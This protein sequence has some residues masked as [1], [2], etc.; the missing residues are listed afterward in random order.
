MIINNNYKYS[1]AVKNNDVLRESYNELTRNTFGFDFVNW[2]E[3]GHWGEMYIPHAITD[4]D[5]VISSIS[6]NLMQFDVGGVKKNYI[7]L[8][9]V[10]TDTQYR[11][12]GLNRKIMEEVLK[13]YEGKVDG[14][15]LFAN[16]SVLNYYTK[17]GFKPSKEYEYYMQ[18]EDKEN[19]KSYVI[20]KVDM[21]H[22]EQCER[23]YDVI[24]NYSDDTN[25][26]NENDAMYMSDNIG[27]YQFWLAA[28]YGKHV[29]YLPEI[30]NYVVAELKGDTLYIYQIFGKQQVDINRL[31]KSFGEKVNEVVLQY[32]PVNK[33]NF[34]VREHKEEDCTLFILGE[35]LQC[36]ER[37]KMMFPILSHA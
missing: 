37:N 3:L 6:V 36:V 13:E 26:L 5:K 9:T 8:G 17:F 10:M 7:Q 1:I 29:Y 27:L 33:E 19:I 21:T 2:Y 25:N 28:E 35:D 16:D 23:L 24:R 14:I 4:G 15:Y 12:R 11:E 18:C 34:S 20:E 22:K 32:T 30:G 31:T